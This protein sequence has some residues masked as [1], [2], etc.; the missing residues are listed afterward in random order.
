M[1]FYDKFLLIKG[2]LDDFEKIK[3]MKILG[4]KMS[5][6]NFEALVLKEDYKED[7]NLVAEVPT[8]D[9]IMI[10]YGRI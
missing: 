2:G 6:V 10:Y 5:K 4:Q 8:I 7:E 1:S 9:E 3:N